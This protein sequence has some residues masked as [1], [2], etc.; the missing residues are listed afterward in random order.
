M[1]TLPFLV[2]VFLRALSG[3]FTRLLVSLQELQFVSHP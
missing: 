3:P 1:D 2:H